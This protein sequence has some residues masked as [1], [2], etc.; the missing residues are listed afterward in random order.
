MKKIVGLLMVVGSCVF[1]V[2]PELSGTPS[3]LRE[4]LNGIPGQLTVVGRAERRVEADRAVVQVCVRT[5]K[6]KLEA[7]LLENNHIRADVVARLKEGGGDEKR[8]H[9]SRFSSRPVHSSW[10]GKVKEYVIESTVR[11]YA[12]SEKELQ[13][14]AGL[15]DEL[16]EV[17]LVSLAF[18][19]TKKDDVNLEL[20][21]EA[22]GKVEKQKRLY[23]SLL[24]VKLVPRKIEDTKVKQ[25][26]HEQWF[27]SDR[28]RVLSYAGAMANPQESIYLHALRNREADVSQFEELVFKAGIAVTFDVY[29]EDGK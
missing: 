13:L 1:G 22:M 12:E 3:M 6:K 20:Q 9:A 19:V 15:V 2:E 7:S 14:V 8:I 21:R 25:I 4:H 17:S 18:E 11:I 23:E 10:S 16:D 28:K 26:S 29:A 27:A 24:G 5:S